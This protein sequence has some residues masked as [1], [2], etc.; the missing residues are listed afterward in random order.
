MSQLPAI[1]QA[2]ADLE[3]TIEIDGVTVVVPTVPLDQT[4]DSLE[5]FRFPCRLITPAGGEVA[6]AAAIARTLGGAAAA[7]ALVIDWTIQDVFCY[8]GADSGL[9]LIDLAPVL[10]AYAAAYM[11]AALR[12]R[13]ARYSVTNVSFPV[14]GSFEWPEVSGRQYDGIVAAVTVREIV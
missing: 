13:T 4:P 7:P 8:R 6:G 3:I 14:F 12:L 11:D 5:S 9:G 1:Y 10:T 2:L